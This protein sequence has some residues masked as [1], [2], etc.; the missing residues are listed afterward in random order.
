MDTPILTKDNINK[1]YIKKNYNAFYNYLLT[2]YTDYKYIKF[3]E[4]VYC[5]KNDIDVHPVCPICGNPTP[6]LDFNRGYQKYCSLK[7]SNSSKDVQIKKVQ[8]SMDN[9]GVEYPAQSNTIMNKIINTCNKK[10]GGIGN[11]SEQIKQKQYK[12]M[13][14]LY[15]VNHAL[16]NND[17]KQ[18]SNTNTIN[19]YSGIGMGS[20][21][22]RQKIE[23]TNVKLYGCVNPTNL[24]KI[25]NKRIL[26]NID[27][28][29]VKYPTQNIGIINK[30]KNSKRNNFY[31]KYNNI[32]D[33]VNNDNGLI[34]T[35]KCPHI[36][37]TKCGEKYYTIKSNMYWDRL[38]N[39]TE[40]CTKL[41]P[42]QMSN[43]KNTSLEIFIKRILD[44][45]NIEYIENDRS[46]LNGK[47]IDIYIP[48]KKIGIECNGIYW[49][50]LKSSPYHVNKWKECKN[51]GIQ[52][53]TIWEDWIINKPDIVRSILLS[54]LGIY[55]N[56]LYA[57]KC[58][59]KEISIGE[60]N[61][62]LD[63][64]HIQ[65]KSRAIVRLGLY[66]NNNIVSVMTF[67]H[68]IHCSGN[69]KIA[70]NQYELIRFCTL[71]NTQVIGG[72]DKLFKYFIRNYNPNIVTSFASNDISNGNLY[73]KLGFNE[74]Q[75]NNSYWY[76]DKTY[77]RYH[78]STFTKAS[79]I[80]RGWASSDKKWKEKDIMKEHGY[81][82]IHDSG[83][84]KYEYIQKK[85]P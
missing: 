41:L 51:N 53:L 49:H 78:R 82:K 14:E 85:E 42:V 60:C 33:V 29:G 19:K 76:I 68:K 71:Q 59:V 15:G 80:K 84:V 34:Y 26:T 8:T 55:N 47:E 37:C 58:I 65:G 48:S 46:I 52:L 72:A 64:N 36:D 3:S 73:R 81:F 40:P 4:L 50:S 10:Y 45:Y 43:S 9:Y 13:N 38:K 32:L 44:K 62:F 17:I 61:N 18:K 79:I 74:L 28:Y 39:H 11:A 6:F 69:N 35:I 31:L 22:I 70:D 54:K 75:T 7:C 56:R 5:Y 24:L 16:Q 1:L 66:N 20:N 83:Q 67:G 30:I 12:T 2:R 27:K 63:I 77:K 23:S 57:R 25:I 21:E